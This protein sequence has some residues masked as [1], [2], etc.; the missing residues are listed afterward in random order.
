MGNDRMDVIPYVNNFILGVVCRDR[1]EDFA[2]VILAE[3]TKMCYDVSEAEVTRAKNQLKAQL[4]FTQDSTHRE[5]ASQTT[6]SQLYNFML[7]YHLNTLYEV[8]KQT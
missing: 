3:L 5:F 6:S 1:C 8:S 2:Y 7:C 4:L